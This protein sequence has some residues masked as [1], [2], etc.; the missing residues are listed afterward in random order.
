ELVNLTGLHFFPTLIVFLALT[1]GLF[2]WTSPSSVGVLAWLGGAVTVAGTTLQLVA[3]NDLRAFRNAH[4]GTGRI[5]DTGVWTWSRHPNY[6]G[7]I[8]V[9]WG[10][11]LVGADAAA[12]LWTITGPLAI[13]GL[14]VFVSIPLIDKRMAARREGW[15]EHVRKTRSL[16]PLPLRRSSGPRAAAE[17]HTR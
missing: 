10:V 4:G 1:G 14:F 16:L 11:W 2:A 12:P 13:T 6:F 15:N 9:W 5:L 8:C 17:S 3:D 7:E